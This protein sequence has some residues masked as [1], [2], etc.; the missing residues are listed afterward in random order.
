MNDGYSVAVL[1]A[2]GLVGETMIS[3]LEERDFPVSELFPLASE[4]SAGSQIKFRD[5]EHEVLDEFVGQVLGD[6]LGGSARDGHPQRAGG[7]W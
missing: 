4:R 6:G 7:R 5:R 3:I 1:G 2:T